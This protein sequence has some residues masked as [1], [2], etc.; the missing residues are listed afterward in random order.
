MDQSQLDALYQQ[1]LGRSV[2]PNGAA[3]WGNAD[4]NTVV[5]GI[6]GSQEYQNRQQPQQ[7]SSYVQQ[8]APQGQGLADAITPDINSIY[9]QYLGRGVDPSG[10]ATYAG[11]DPQRIIDA[12]TSSQEYRNR[13]GGGNAAQPAVATGNAQDLA[14]QVFSLYRTNQNYDK[15]LNQLNALPQDADYYKARIGLIGQMMGWQAGQGTQGN[16]AVLQKELQSYLPGAQASGLNANDITGLINTNAQTQAKVNAE[17][18]AS[19]AK[20]PQGWV[21]QNIPGG[22]A[23]LAAAAAVAAPYL[24][25]ELFASL[26]GVAAG[27]DVTGIIGADIA[28]MTAAGATEAEIASTLMANYGLTPE[29]ANSAM[30]QVAQG[31]AGALT[32]GIGNMAFDASNFV[33]PLVSEG[34]I[35]I[36]ASD[37]AAAAALAN[38]GMPLS[39]L[40]SLLKTGATVG[41]IASKFLGNNQTPTKTN[42]SL[43]TKTTTNPTGTNPLA[44]AL[45]NLGSSGQAQ[46]GSGFG[47]MKGNVN[48]FAYT[49]DVPVQTLAAN[50]ADPFAAL[51][52]AQTPITPYNPL[53]HLVG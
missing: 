34:G 14:N 53:A 35:D 52:V 2:D 29:L 19:D 18:I 39:T 50:K 6:L 4:Y 15:Q 41:S 21:N 3:S 49:K 40:A 38:A 37:A 8:P 1:Y 20:G 32:S 46:T 25:P 47:L 26:G 24:A 33:G 48:P 36:A 11:W 9:Q 22:Y 31:G 23:T 13:A 27:A 7:Q 51:N 12:V 44:N 45:N 17:R 10:A 16:N 28:S 30:Y 42:P 5:Q 43:S